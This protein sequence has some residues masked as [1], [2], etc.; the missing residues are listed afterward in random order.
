[1]LSH[2]LPFICEAPAPSRVGPRSV[3]YWPPRLTPPGSVRDRFGRCCTAVGRRA[4]GRVPRS[5]ITD[6]RTDAGIVIARP[7]KLTGCTRAL[8]AF[9]EI[10]GSNHYACGFLMHT[11]TTPTGIIYARQDSLGATSPENCGAKM[12]DC[13]H[14]VIFNLCLYGK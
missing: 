1:M 10:F 13:N 3:E 5:Y 2:N 6:T 14:F 9:W 7:V 11:H 8:P 12:L 4:R